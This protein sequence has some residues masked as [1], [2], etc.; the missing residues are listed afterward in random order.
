M[1]DE[2]YDAESLSASEWRR[3]A[4]KREEEVIALR[5]ENE[6][7]A[8]K[9]TD[10]LHTTTEMRRDLYWHVEQLTKTLQP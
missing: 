7:L 3:L 2:R 9:L 1:A 10:I 4:N 8:R 6:R 5:R